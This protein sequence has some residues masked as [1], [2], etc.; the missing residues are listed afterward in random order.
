MAQME[1]MLAEE[2][3]N[4][5]DEVADLNE[6]IGVV[7]DNEILLRETSLDA[8][9]WAANKDTASGVFEQ[10]FNTQL[11]ADT[12]RLL[13]YLEDI[14]FVG[15]VRMTSHLGRF[16]LDIDELGNYQLA[17]DSKTAVECD[18]IGHPLDSSSRVT[19]RLSVPFGRIQFAYRE[20]PV[21]LELVALSGPETL[22]L[23]IYPGQAASVAE[24]NQVAGINN[25]VDIELIPR[26]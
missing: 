17:D 6:Q 9:A 15:T 8:L 19:D 23:A 14:G 24:W 5:A 22:D 10:A 3:A 13:S 20:G 11:A 12:E 18:Y 2:T 25:R 26:N 1:A 21:Q 7:A 4:R 16:C